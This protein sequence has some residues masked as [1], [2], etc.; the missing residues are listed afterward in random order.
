MES[1]AKLARDVKASTF[2]VVKPAVSVP[3]Q[4][5]NILSPRLL[6]VVLVASKIATSSK[7]LLY[8]R[9][10]SRFSPLERFEQ[11]LET[12]DS[13]R[14][15]IP[16][17]FIVLVDNSNLSASWLGSLK[18]KSDVVIN[19]WG[20]KSLA[21][22]TD[23]SDH[24]GLGEC[25]LLDQGMQW[26]EDRQIYAQNIF[27]LSGRYLLNANFS[28]GTFDNT[29]NVFKRPTFGDAHDLK[30]TY[31]YTSFFKVSH[32]HAH[33]FHEALRTIIASLK[34]MIDINTPTAMFDD[35][36]SRLPYLLPDIKLVPELGVTQRVSPFEVRDTHI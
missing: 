11:T 19:D 7:P 24:K 9:V 15:R 14:L 34:H 36:E 26:L 32:L 6:N 29:Q 25:L 8:T 27:K 31:I 22:Y 3:P 33:R 20:N 18:D 21:F 4:W 28:M 23:E 17:S 5:H 10:R 13:I 16:D 35:L 2:R 1:V 30:P 12:L